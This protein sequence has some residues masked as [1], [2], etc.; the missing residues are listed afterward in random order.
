MK[1]A[2]RVQYVRKVFIET[3]FASP[4]RRSGRRILA[5]L[6]PLFAILGFA[7]TVAAADAASPVQR[8]ILQ[9]F[10]I[11]LVFALIIG[12][13]VHI[14]LLAAVQWY[15]DS[16]RWR[17]GKGAAKTHDRRL[18]IGWTVGPV[19]I[20]AAVVIVTMIAI[21]NIERPRDYDYALDV[22][23]A[24]WAW[25]YQYPKYTFADNTTASVPDSSGTMYIQEG[26]TFLLRVQSEDVIHSFYVPDL[27]IKIDAVP[28]ITNIFWVRADIAGMYTVQ[29]AEFCGL[30]H[31]QMHGT[32]VVFPPG[33][34]TIPY[35]PPPSASP[36]GG[37]PPKYTI[38]DLAFKETPGPCFPTLA[39]SIEP[40]RLDL[41]ANFDV[42]FRVWNNETAPHQFRMGPPFNILGPLQPAKSPPVHFNLNT[43]GPNG[44]HAYW[45]DVS[46]HRPLGMEGLL[47]VT[48]PAHYDIEITDASIRPSQ[49]RAK[50]GQTMDVT[51]YNNGTASAT[52]GIGPPYNIDFGSISP[53]SS[54]PA[55][56]VL[57]RTADPPTWFGGGS[58]GQRGSLYVTF[59]SA[60]PP[61]PPP[62][63]GFPVVEVTFGLAGL[64]AVAAL[65]LNFRLARAARRRQR[66]PPEET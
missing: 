20:L 5:V 3:R 7:P 31:S 52:F 12:V 36:P 1:I 43:G 49:I 15:R 4:V 8:E 11:I 44:Q 32:V 28:G 29:C 63:R 55:T 19:L 16:P 21:P 2:S 53:A 26:V 47:N 22:I 6:V 54:K 35:G 62:P 10:F 39:W 57:N 58:P 38:V 33:T 17:P 24:Q 64:A 56:V 59:T 65:V 13:L 14:L 46:G 41:G 66:F 30:G 25:R 51:V 37:E 48:G 23:G 18:E 34:Q 40:C 27:G 42:T 50:L 9:L 45:C 61:P 60:A